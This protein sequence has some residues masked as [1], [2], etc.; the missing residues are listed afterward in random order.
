MKILD[1]TCGKRGI[2]FDK[3]FRDAVYI[4]VRPEVEPQIIMDCTRTTFREKEFDLIVFDP[5]H[6]NVGANSDMTKS[7]GHFTSQQI[8]ELIQGADLEFCRILK[9]EGFLLFKWND[10]DQKLQ[11][12]LELMPHF[13]ALFG[14]K[15]SERSLHASV[16]SWVC[17]IKNGKC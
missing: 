14:Q 10:H 13:K 16:T 15:T 3:E 17:L 4:D 5:P 12:M 8:R 2:W 7:Y 11:R 6:V 1:A 9:D